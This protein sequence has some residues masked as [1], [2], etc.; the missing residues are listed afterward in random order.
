MA[1]A[2]LIACKF[3]IIVLVR[4][5]EHWFKRWGYTAQKPIERAYKQ[6]PEALAARLETEY[7]RMQHQILAEGVEIYYGD[8]TCVRTS[9]LRG[10]GFAPRGHTPVGPLLSQRTSVS[11]V[12]AISNQGTLRFRVLE[13][14]IDAKTLVAFHKRLCRDAGRRVFLILD[15]LN[16]RKA[17]EMRAW[18]AAQADEIAL[19]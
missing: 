8:E 9:D 14:A 15:Q 17:C 10:R 5:T 4:T 6:R 11:L 13:E 2:A 12:S 1:I 7:P 18:V 19:F 16:A 3:G